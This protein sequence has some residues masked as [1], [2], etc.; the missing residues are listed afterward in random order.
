VGLGHIGD[1]PGG[2]G[3]AGIEAGGGDG[4]EVIG[5]RDAGVVDGC[6]RAKRDGGREPTSDWIGIGDGAWG[7]HGKDG[8][9]GAGSRGDGLRGDR[10]GLGHIGEV[11]GGTGGA[12]IEA[13]GGDG[14][15]VIGERNAGVVDGR[16]GAERDGGREPTSDWIGVVSAAWGEHGEDGIHRAG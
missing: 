6:A 2:A 11:Q 15:E 5:E 12:G 1:V 8:I 10:V 4:W 14:R 3:G 7:E 9:H 13:G 16:A